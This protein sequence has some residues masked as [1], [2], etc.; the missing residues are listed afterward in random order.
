M[1]IKIG[2]CEVE[3]VILLVVQMKRPGCITCV[4]Q[5]YFSPHGSL[6]FGRK[7]TDAHPLLVVTYLIKSLFNVKQWISGV[8]SVKIMAR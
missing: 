1:Q 8:L 2:L 4:A 6:D 7:K 3:T 5:L